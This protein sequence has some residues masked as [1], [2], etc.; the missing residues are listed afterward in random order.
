MHL[1]PITVGVAPFE[2]IRATENPEPPAAPKDKNLRGDD[3]SELPVAR[4]GPRTHFGFGSMTIVGVVPS[5]KSATATL[6]K[7]L[8]KP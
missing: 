8:W 5:L 1:P 2:K 3:F 4:A 6:A 7:P